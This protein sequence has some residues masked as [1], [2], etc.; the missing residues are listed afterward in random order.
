MANGP[1]SRPGEESEV[2]FSPSKLWSRWQK[3]AGNLPV[4]VRATYPGQPDTALAQLALAKETL[5]CK[6][7]GRVASAIH[8][9]TEGLESRTLSSAIAR[10]TGANPSRAKI[11]STL[12]PPLNISTLVPCASHVFVS[13][14][15]PD[16]LLFRSDEAGANLLDTYSAWREEVK[17]SL[18]RRAGGS[19]AHSDALGVSNADLRLTSCTSG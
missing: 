9:R 11:V 13:D 10:A 6:F 15:D 1:P 5:R 18:A 2:I 4:R 3:P 19:P 14:K 17:P 7:C 8:W 12:G 16:V